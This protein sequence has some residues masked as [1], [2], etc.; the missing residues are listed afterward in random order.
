VGFEGILV[1][2]DQQIGNVSFIKFEE[3]NFGH[4]E[5]DPIE[6]GHFPLKLSNRHAVHHFHIEVYMHITDDKIVPYGFM[7]QLRLFICEIFDDFDAFT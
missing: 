5:D 2:R 7:V 1:L 6:L 3:V 4:V